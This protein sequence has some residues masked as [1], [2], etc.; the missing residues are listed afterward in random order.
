[1]LAL[2]TGGTSG[3]G[4]ELCLLLASKGIDLLITGRNENELKSLQERLSATVSVTTLS[5]D[6]DRA[7]GRSR[8][9]AAIHETCPDFIF[10]NAGFGFV[11]DALTY[12]TEE[13]LSILEVNIKALVEFT[14]EGARTLISKDKRGVIL[15]VSSA[16]AFFILP[17]FAVYAASKT[18]V[19]N[20]SEAFDAEV[21]PYG[22][23][24]LTAC[25]GFVA[26]NFSK[27]SRSRSDK[28]RT[29]VLSASFVAE[30]I[31]DQIEALQPVRIIDWKYRLLNFFSY[32]IPG[33]LKIWIGQRLINS[34]KKS[35]G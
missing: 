11:G 15:N 23:R 13:Q 17:G 9:T 35:P 7:E 14:L 8:I 1:M 21:K 30:Q 3:I 28:K 29:A 27:R 12:S 2:V 32:F 24:V 5:A 20:F 31:W 10:N 22:V 18:F 6:L 25:P 33:R 4:K 16:A 26:T 34:R 19:L